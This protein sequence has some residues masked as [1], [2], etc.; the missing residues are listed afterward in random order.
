MIQ[1]VTVNPCCNIVTG[2]KV[3]VLICPM[4]LLVRTDCIFAKFS[5]S[6]ARLLVG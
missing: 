4:E 3:R 5:G 6:V 2:L 1:P